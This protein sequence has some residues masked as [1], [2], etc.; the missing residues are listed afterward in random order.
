MNEFEIYNKI[1]GTVEEYITDI[2]PIK[3]KEEPDNKIYK[4]KFM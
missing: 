3:M 4:E 2:L 1:F